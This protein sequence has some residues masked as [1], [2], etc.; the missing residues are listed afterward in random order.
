MLMRNDRSILR[1]LAVAGAATVLSFFTVPR[2]AFAAQT[3]ADTLIDGT[4]D[5][6]TALDPAG[7]YDYGSD[8]ADREIFQHLMVIPPGGGVPAP[9]L[10]TRCSADTSMQNWTCELRK[11]VKFQ[12][13]DDFT[14]ADV[15]FS[16]DRVIKIH[17]PSGIWGLLANLKSVTTDGPYKVTFHLKQPQSTWEYILGTSAGYIVDHKVYPADKIRPSTDPQVGTGPYRLVKYVPGQIA[18][19]KAWKGYWGP[20]PRTP[21]LIITYFS[22]SS[23]MKLALQRGELDMAFRTFSPTEL[24][25]LEK[26]KG[27]KVYKGPGVAIR[28]LVLSTKRPPTDKLAV[29]E[30]LAYLIPREAIAKN[31]YHGFVDPLYSMVPA[32]LPGHIDA[33]ETVYGKNPNPAKARA[34]LE[35]AG[36]ETPVHITLWWTPTHYGSASAEEYTEMQRALDA[37]GLFK[38][39][40][41]SAEWATYAK[42]LGTQ[43]NAY[44]LGWFPDYPDAEDYLV[45]FYDSSSNFTS[46]GY[47]SPKMNRILSKEKAA[48]T[49]AARMKYVRE[50]QM[51]AARDVPIIPYFQQAMVVV[52]RDDVHGIDKTLDTSFLMRF[53]LLGKS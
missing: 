25:S 15:K 1:L 38:V 49:T 22:K 16:F 6:V 41:K 27:I 37:S 17:D 40:L 4:T 5:T 19:Y 48:R 11:G 43:Y 45:P 14:S 34:V 47:D 12:N 7:Q 21:N 42:T 46:N 2:F 3:P 44:Q 50:A 30:A 9:Q 29:R 26:A 10:A 36:I 33:F 53:W 35:K 32:G 28:Y 31:V 51:L 24:L 13:G 20:K 18:V 23:T 52:A 39:T 8:T